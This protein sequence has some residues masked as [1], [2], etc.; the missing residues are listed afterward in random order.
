MYGQSAGTQ[1]KNGRCRDVT[2]SGG[3]TA[4]Q[5]HL[6]EGGGGLIEVGGLFERGPYLI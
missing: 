5:T 3:F 4:L 2:V 1:K 6:R